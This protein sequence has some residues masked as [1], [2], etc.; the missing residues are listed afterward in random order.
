MPTLRQERL[1]EALLDPS[2]TTKKQAL[3]AAG[4]SKVS[5]ERNPGLLI[6][7]SGTRRAKAELEASRSD[8]AR[9]IAT[10]ASSQ[11]LERL[12]SMPDAAVVLAWKTAEELKQG[13]PEEK[14]AFLPPSY[15][16]DRRRRKAYRHFLTGIRYALAMLDSGQLE[17]L[18]AMGQPV[19][20]SPIQEP[21]IDYST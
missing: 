21:L 16:R 11:V 10:K 8:R 7:G 9:Q 13:E 2:I 20:V 14:K 3:L 19:Q 17:A 12:D 5:A 6:G 18:R 15:L 1:A 4:Y